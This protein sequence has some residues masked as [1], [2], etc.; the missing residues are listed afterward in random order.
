MVSPWKRGVHPDVH[1]TAFLPLAVGTTLAH[2]FLMSPPMKAT[3]VPSPK[4]PSPIPSDRPINLRRLMVDTL[5]CVGQVGRDGLA[6]YLGGGTVVAFLDRDFLGDELL[7]VQHRADADGQNRQSEREPVQRCGQREEP[8]AL[9]AER[10]VFPRPEQEDHQQGQ[11]R[12]TAQQKPIRDCAFGALLGLG[13]LDGPAL[14]LEDGLDAVDPAAEFNQFFAGH[15]RQLGVGRLTGDAFLA[16][17]VASFD[18]VA[19]ARDPIHIEMP[20]TATIPMIHAAM[21]SGAGPK[22]PRP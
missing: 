16:W 21:P 17:A 1:S 8:L 15:L 10:L 7:L 5:E 20:I 22:P 2:G 4:A 14:R 12:N 19:H 13:A 3:S 6:V 11:A 18:V 9:G